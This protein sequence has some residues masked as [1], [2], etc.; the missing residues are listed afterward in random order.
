MKSKMDSDDGCDDEQREERDVSGAPGEKSARHRS[1]EV[2]LQ[3]L[4]ALDVHRGKV[5]DAEAQEI[6][7]AVAANFEMPEAA[8]A[9]A[10]ELVCGVASSIGEIDAAVAAAARN[11]RVE[12]MAVVDRNVL[13]LATYELRRAEAPTA[14]VIDEAVRMAKRF[15]DD[16]SPGFVNGVLDAIAQEL[17]G[18]GG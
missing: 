16:P 9:F 1:R 11:W 18:S 7:E 2:A 14:V 6:F 8:K 13:R 10:K 4:F 3:A 12:R 15:G 17:R 5:A